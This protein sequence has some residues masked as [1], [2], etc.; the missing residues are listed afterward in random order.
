[1]GLAAGAGGMAVVPGDKGV[2]G[3][4]RSSVGRAPAREAALPGMALTDTRGSTDFRARVHF[5]R[6]IAR[7]ITGM[8]CRLSGQPS[9]P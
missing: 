9:V 8:E 3:D 6:F 2:A 7:E 1:V 5:G 4:P